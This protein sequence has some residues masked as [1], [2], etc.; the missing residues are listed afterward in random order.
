MH[1]SRLLGVALGRLFILYY[2]TLRIRA[3][4]G[5][6]SVIH[7]RD[8]P[9]DREIFAISER[10]VIAYIGSMVGFTVLV[11]HGRD[12]DWVAAGL[13]TI[14]CV[15]KGFEVG[16]VDFYSLREDRP[17]FLCWK[18]GEE[19][20]THW[21]ETDTGFAGRQPIDGAILSSISS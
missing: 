15:V 4:M 18:L 21:H 14:G 2:R 11:A 3:L 13:E 19:R 9:Y 12:G 6:G 8:F 16:L 7:P 10:D 1:L 17:I 5:D 20:I